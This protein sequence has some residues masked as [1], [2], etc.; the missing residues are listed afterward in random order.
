MISK[1]IGQYIELGLSGNIH[2]FGMLIE[3]SLDI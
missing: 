2:V 1:Y 3:V